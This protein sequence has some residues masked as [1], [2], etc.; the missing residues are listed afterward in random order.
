MS[1]SA[2][3]SIKQVSASVGFLAML[4]FAPSDVPLIAFVVV[5]T[6]FGM[7]AAYPKDRQYR[8]ETGTP[9]GRWFIERFALFGGIVIF[10]L[11]LQDIKHAIGP[12]VGIDSAV[13][14]AW[15]AVAFVMMFSGLKGLAKIEQ[16]WFYEIRNRSAPK[17]DD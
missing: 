6:F 7:L 10:V 5:G 16:R 2:S 9:I 15:G 14:R 3:A 13:P 12:S 4:G 17:S 11:G 8:V 1:I